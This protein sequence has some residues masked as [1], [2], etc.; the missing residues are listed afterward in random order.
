MI[1][2]PELTFRVIYHPEL[3][4]MV[5]YHPELTCRV[6]YHPE[7]TCRVIYLRFLNFWGFNST[8]LNLRRIVAI[9]FSREKKRNEKKLK[10]F[11]YYY[12][13]PNCDRIN[14]SKGMICH[15]NIY[16]VFICSK[17]SDLM[18]TYI[19]LFSNIF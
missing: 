9:H 18:F 17:W 16:A 11:V 1:Y 6:I 10:N 4:C 7:P 8:I 5:I 14:N 13:L 12:S 3:T 2:H 15:F 19:I